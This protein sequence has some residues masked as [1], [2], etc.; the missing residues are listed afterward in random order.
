MV[1]D[2]NDDDK[3]IHQYQE[4]EVD[5]HRTMVSVLHYHRQMVNLFVHQYIYVQP[6]MMFLIVFVYK[7]NFLNIYDNYL[8]IHNHHHH[9]HHYHYLIFDQF[10]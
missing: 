6:M 4:M 9:H 10:V 1:D 3:V 8:D 5:S 7:E 2:D